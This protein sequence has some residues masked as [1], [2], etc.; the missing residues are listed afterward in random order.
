VVVVHQKRG[1]SFYLRQW[2]LTGGAPPIPGPG[3][4]RG[5]G[6]G[7][8][9][10]VDFSPAPAPAGAIKIIGRGPQI[11]TFVLAFSTLL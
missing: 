7:S 11:A 8:G 9:R 1:I 4:N 2:F 3:N 10:G 5:P 6:P